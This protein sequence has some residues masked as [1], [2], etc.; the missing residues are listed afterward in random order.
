MK[1]LQHGIGY[2]QG[3]HTWSAQVYCWSGAPSVQPQPGR[4]VSSTRQLQTNTCVWSNIATIIIMHQSAA[5]L[6]WHW[7]LPLGILNM[8]K[9]LASS[10]V[11]K[12]CSSH[13]AENTAVRRVT[14][15]NS[16]AF[17]KERGSPAAAAAQLAEPRRVPRAPVQEGVAAAAAPL[18]LQHDLPLTMLSFAPSSSPCDQDQGCMEHLLHCRMCNWLRT[19]MLC[20]L[21]GSFLC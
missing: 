21:Q 5:P 3:M 12:P 2:K 7:C 13:K 8:H 16:M 10:G 17:A 15:L 11:H 20:C 9:P 18:R 6:L 14:R 19:Q 1:R 4:G